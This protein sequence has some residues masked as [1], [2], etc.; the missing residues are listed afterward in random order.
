MKKKSG[1]A[2]EASLPLSQEPQCLFL[3]PDVMMNLHEAASPGTKSTEAAAA[4]A[5]RRTRVFGAAARERQSGPDQ[6]CRGESAVSPRETQF[7]RPIC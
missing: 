6:T 7:I 1:V 5:N 2:R 4:N 3:Q